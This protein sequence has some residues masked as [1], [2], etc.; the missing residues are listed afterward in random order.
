MKILQLATVDSGG[1][2]YFYRDAILQHTEHECRAIRTYQGWMD[3]PHDLVL[4]R[5][6][7]LQEIADLYVWADVVHLHDEAGAMVLKWREK[8]TIVTY[9]GTRYRKFHDQINEKILSRGWKLSCSTID[10]TWW[11][12]TWIPTPRRDV[13]KDWNPAKKFTVVHAPSSRD[14][15]K[16]D[17]YLEALNGFNFQLI[18]NQPY[19]KCLQKKARGSI[20]IDGWRGYGNN[21]VEAWAMGMPVISGVPFLVETL[22]RVRWG[23]VPFAIVDLRPEY[24]REV[25]EKMRDD[26][27][28]YRL[29]KDLGR[30]HYER[31]HHPAKVAKQLIG[32]Y[33]AML[34]G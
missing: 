17:L 20:L 31:Y 33:E 34:D 6:E 22:M 4:N 7:D 19:K 3:Y 1:A 29:Y 16:T 8:P 26:Q 21:A 28:Y 30:T 12:A 13:A 23:Y 9:H 14:K 15:K 27:N 10:L 25:V 5:K 24:I 18:E 2:T 11:G 32:L